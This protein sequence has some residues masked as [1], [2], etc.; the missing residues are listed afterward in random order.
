MG[1]SLLTDK[2]KR[3]L[4][5]QLDYNKEFEFESDRDAG[6]TRY[7]IRKKIMDQAV[8]S[9]IEYA[10]DWEVYYK[11]N[12]D[13]KGF[14]L[15][16]E[17]VSTLKGQLANASIK[18]ADVIN[19]WLP[20]QSIAQF[21][22]RLLTRNDQCPFPE[23]V[24]DVPQVMSGLSQYFSKLSFTDESSEQARQQILQSIETIQANLAVGTPVVEQGNMRKPDGTLILLKD[25]GYEITRIDEDIADCCKWFDEE[26]QK[27][28]YTVCELQFNNDGKPFLC[29]FN[30]CIPYNVLQK[31]CHTV[32]KL[33]NEGRIPTEDEA[34]SALIDVN[35]LIDGHVKDLK[36]ADRSISGS[37]V[38]I[39]KDIE[40]FG[41]N[42]ERG[43]GS[44]GHI[45]RE[46]NRL[47]EKGLIEKVGRKIHVTP[48]GYRVFS[49]ARVNS[50]TYT[51]IC[52]IEKEYM[53][54]YIEYSIK[55]GRASNRK[56]G[57]HI[58]LKRMAHLEYH[59]SNPR[60]VGLSDEV[61]NNLYA[62]VNRKEDE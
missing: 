4:E 27:H 13:C 56:N 53:V 59:S 38:N 49:S 30:W 47:V 31:G 28:I 17:D 10:H 9:L 52:E 24:L 44:P 32:D 58:F 37:L 23:Y 42:V 26:C 41:K 14:L 55:H 62:N 2:E 8:P 46:I 16:D 36:D 48:M 18:V 21:I 6:Q 15:N 19:E 54:D 25:A 61:M 3:Y 57:A 51:D 7:R 29:A 34:S 39:A 50:H 40:R 43:G 22:Y 35:D 33:L 11:I 12:R 45:T 20:K 5:A 60:I 1:Q